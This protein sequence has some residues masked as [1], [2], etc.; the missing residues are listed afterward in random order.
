M[1]VHA[2]SMFMRQS[3]PITSPPAACSSLKNPEVPCAIGPSDRVEGRE[4]VIR[5]IAGEH[6][7]E[8]RLHTDATKGQQTALLPLVLH[9]ELLIPELDP[10]QP[11]RVRRMRG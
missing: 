5:R 9:G 10:G 1:S 8:P 4:E 2:W 6:V 3:T 11:A 7:G